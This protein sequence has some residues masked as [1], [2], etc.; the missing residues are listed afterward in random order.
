MKLLYLLLLLPGLVFASGNHNKSDCGDKH[1]THPEC[2]APA[3][4]KGDKGDR[5]RTG[6]TGAQ[7]EQGETGAQGDTGARGLVG[8]QGERGLSGE[9]G[10]AGVVSETWIK[11]VRNFNNKYSKYMAASESV[12]IYLPQNQ[13]SRV[14]FGL[15]RV[16]GETG[17]GVGYA[18]K[19]ADDIAFTLGL[20]TSGGETVGKMSVGF[21]FGGKES[22][23]YVPY[24][25]CT[26]VKGELNFEQKCVKE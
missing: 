12:Q 24:N 26:Y 16:H 2:A 21:E 1:H 9:R 25:E 8:P 5:G 18:Y 11:E 19:S 4:P 10:L 14:T 3:G 15:G 23:G 7:G 22:T 17:L 6:K 13:H 20:G